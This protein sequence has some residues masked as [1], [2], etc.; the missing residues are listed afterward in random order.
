MITVATGGT[1]VGGGGVLST[2]MNTGMAA[3]TQQPLGSYSHK[4]YHG[5]GDNTVVGTLCWYK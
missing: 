2:M 1:G 3:I 4:Q 5:K